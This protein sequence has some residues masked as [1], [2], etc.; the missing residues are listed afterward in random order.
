LGWRIELDDAATGRRNIQIH[1]GNI[2]SQIAGCIL[3]GRSTNPGAGCGCAVVA[4][5]PYDD[6][7][8]GKVDPAKQCNPAIGQQLPILES[9]AARDEIKLRY[10]ENNNRPIVLVVAN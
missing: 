3:V 1:S 7:G 2:T 8:L 6:C 4:P 9:R 5:P 10:G